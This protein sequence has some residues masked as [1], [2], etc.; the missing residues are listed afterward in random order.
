[1]AKIGNTVTKVP[2][3]IGLNEKDYC[4]C[5]LTTLKSMEEKYALSMTE[6]SNE[7]LYGIYKN[8]FLTIADM[9]RRLFDLMFQN[10]W[11]QLENVE[12]KKLTDK[13]NMLNSD[14]KGLSE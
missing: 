6:A 1:M 9:Q 5:L 11:Y 10:G 3:G 2:G 13:Y 14:Y 4:F 8:T 12:A 7:W